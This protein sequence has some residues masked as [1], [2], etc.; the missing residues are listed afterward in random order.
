[1]I[2][3]R[4]EGGLGNQM[5]QAAFGLQ[6]A[7]QHQT[8]LVLDLS[9]YVDQ[10]AHGYLLDR[11]S[12]EARPLRS[13][14][15]AYLPRRYQNQPGSAWPDWLVTSRL[16]RLREKPFGFSEHY[17]RAGDNSYLVG[18]WQSDKFF[19]DVDTSPP[20]VPPPRRAQRFRPQALGAIARPGQHGLAHTSRR[21]L[22]ESTSRQ[23][24]QEPQPRLLSPRRNGSTDRTHRGGSH[25]LL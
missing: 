5:F 7:H 6:L 14:E 19:S 25:C 1:M 24:L 16:K 11:F 3:V 9:S 15:M 21:L 4:V 22:D 10:P 13:D 17:L 12:L 8:E 2:V 20:P 23:H 18:Y